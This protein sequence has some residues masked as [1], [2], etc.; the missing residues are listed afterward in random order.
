MAVYNY[1]VYNVANQSERIP[2]AVWYNDSIYDYYTGN[3]SYL[4]TN[5]FDLIGST[6]VHSRSTT[7]PVYYVTDIY[8]TSFDAINN[9]SYQTGS[10]GDY[11]LE[12]SSIG[13]NALG[14]SHQLYVY[15]FTTSVV[16]GSYSHTIQAEDGSYPNDGQRG[17]YWYVKGAPF[18][19]EITQQ[20]ESQGII[21]FTLNGSVP[22]GYGGYIRMLINGKWTTITE[23]VT[24]NGTKITVNRSEIFSA[25]GS[26]IKIHIYPLAGGV[27][28]ETLTWELKLSSNIQYNQSG[29]IRNVEAKYNHNGV[30]KN[31]ECWYNHNGVLKKV[32]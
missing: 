18:L 27:V 10:R 22:S 8:P 6:K 13:T 29:T 30:I 25:N 21:T 26:L 15:N 17:D 1:D 12:L 31:V 16:R 4:L 7:T 14:G 11:L 9:A 2:V 19:F 5:R 23:K 28:N 3:T 20:T 24:V 32:Q